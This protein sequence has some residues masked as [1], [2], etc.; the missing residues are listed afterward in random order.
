MTKPK[1]NVS[2]STAIYIAEMNL[3]LADIELS[4]LVSWKANGIKIP[5]RVWTVIQAAQTRLDKA[6]EVFNV[7]KD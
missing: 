7:R 6:V 5:K 1:E 2:L 3:R 4:K